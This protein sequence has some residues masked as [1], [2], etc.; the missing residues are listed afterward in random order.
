[1]TRSDPE[2]SDASIP[3]DVAADGAHGFSATA[4]A[5]QGVI[6]VVDDHELIRNSI[7]QVLLRE[8]V[9]SRVVE[10]GHFDEALHQFDDPDV[11]L[12]ICDLR[13]P[14]M[15]STRDLG[16]LRSKRPDVRIIVLSGSESRTDILAALEA[17]VHG[18]IVKKERTDVVLERIKHVLAGEMYVPPCLAILTE[19]APMANFAEPSEPSVEVLTPRQREVLQL[20]TEGL[21]NKAIGR[22]LGVAEGT[23]KMHVAT[24]LKAIDAN[25]R[26]HAAAIGKKFL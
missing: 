12:A 1:M 3:E 10:A 21:S 14:G 15:A 22:Q 24:I 19:E 23:V 4:S 2:T 25:N 18:Y 11:Y 9:D 17:G 7:A 6:L 8:F 16:K 26:A 5:R 13:L 20:I